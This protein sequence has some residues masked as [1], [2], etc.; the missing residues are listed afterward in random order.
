MIK[1]ITEIL[2]RNDYHTTKS[3]QEISDLIKNVRKAVANPKMFRRVD[4]VTAS[5]AQVLIH[6]GVAGKP[7]PTDTDTNVEQT[8]TFIEPTD[9][10]ETIVGT[11][12]DYNSIYYPNLTEGLDLNAE[13][14]DR[15][16]RR[17]GKETDTNSNQDQNDY[18]TESTES[19]VGVPDDSVLLDDPNESQESVDLQ[20]PE[21]KRKRQ[22]RE[23]DEEYVP[24]K[25]KMKNL[26]MNKPKPKTRKSNEHNISS[27]AYADESITSDLTP[28]TVLD[29]DDRVFGTANNIAHIKTEKGRTSKNVNETE[30]IDI[31]NTIQQR[32]VENQTANVDR[33]RDNASESILL[34]DD[35]DVE[36]VPS[37]VPDVIP[38]VNIK[39]EKQQNKTNSKNDAPITIKHEK[40]SNNRKED[41]EPPIP[42]HKSLLTNKNFIKIVA[43]TY[44][45]KNPSM[46]EEGAVLAAQYS[47]LKALKVLEATN[48]EITSGPI[49]D[50]AVQV[51]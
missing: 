37:I 17:Q 36:T 25:Q 38:Q 43:H 10:A 42:L 33:E 45:T 20:V 41:A 46:D 34:S 16:R 29:T 13:N 30:V 15:K 12:A 8:Q 35:D 27:N 23:S 3:P 19:I 44:L 11:P 6:E 1:K 28:V 31:E 4:P 39:R 22:R 50:I 47:T 48:K 51:C 26:S 40:Q 2:I 18:D 5:I 7:V 24:D 21:R 14:S 32:P 9:T 49:Y